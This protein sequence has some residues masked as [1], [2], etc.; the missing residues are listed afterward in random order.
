ML[1]RYHWSLGVGHTYS[2]RS[3]S[4]QSEPPVL[5]YM[6]SII[7]TKEGDH[8]P[9]V[10][11]DPRALNEDEED[12]DPDDPELVMDERENE[13]LGLEPEWDD[14]HFGGEPDNDDEFQMYYM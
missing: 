6:D 12:P 8:D 5:S 13:D 1:M 11:E 4:T 9:T 3:D 7:D 14:D 2:H 10:S